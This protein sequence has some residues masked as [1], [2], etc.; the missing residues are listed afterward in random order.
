MHSFMTSSKLKTELLFP[1]QFIVT[2]PVWLT[3][4]H[5]EYRQNIQSK[6]EGKY[7]EEV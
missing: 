6:K 2:C 5:N 4:Y 1:K 7:Q 3:A